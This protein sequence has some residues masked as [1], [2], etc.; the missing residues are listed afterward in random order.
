M[1]RNPKMYPMEKMF[2]DTNEIDARTSL[3]R[4]LHKRLSTKAR[5]F[6]NSYLE[7]MFRKLTETSDIRH[8]SYISLTSPRFQSLTFLRD[9][10]NLYSHSAPTTHCPISRSGG[11]SPSN[12]SV[13]I[14]LEQEER[15]RGC[16]PVLVL[17]IT[18]LDSKQESCGFFKVYEL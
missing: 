6:K 18:I 12:R 13:L 10:P 11:R 7:E 17:W 2:R 15:N 1:V 14:L 3:N 8:K 4:C 9:S 16:A 5:Y